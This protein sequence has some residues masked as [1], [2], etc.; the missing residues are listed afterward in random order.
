MQW[1]IGALVMFPEQNRCFAWL[2]AS[3]LLV[4]AGP[5]SQTTVRAQDWVDPR[6][7][8]GNEE[9]IS[10]SAYEPA[11]TQQNVWMV[12]EMPTPY[13][14]LYLNYKGTA[15]P[16]IIAAPSSLGATVARADDGRWTVNVNRRQDYEVPDQRAP[17]IQLSVEDASRPYIIPVQL[18]NVLDNAPVMT[19]ENYCEISELQRDFTSDCLYK[20][21]HAD[22]FEKGNIL[23]SSTNELSFEIEDAIANEHFEFWEVPE[24]KPEDPN[25]N[26][27]YN[28]RVKKQLDYAEKSL[29][30]FITTVYDLDRTHSFKMN[31]IV[32]VRNVDSRNPTFTRP[33]TTQRIME[34]EEF[35]TTVIAIDTDTELNNPICYRLQTLVLDYQKYF[36]I[37]ETSGEMIVQPIDRDTEK[38]ELYSFTITAYK[39]HN[40]SNRTSIDGAIILEDKNDCWPE[41]EVRPVELEFWENM[42]MELS[43]EQFIIDD[44]D[45]GENARYTVRLTETVGGQEQETDSFTIIPSSGY[46]RTAFT[47]NINNASKLDFEDPPRQSFQLHATAQEPSEPSHVRM[48]TIAIKLK[49]WNDEI[50]AFSEPEYEVSVR[51]TIEGNELLAEVTVTDRDIGDGIT[52]T[53]LGRIAESLDIV[54]LPI[55]VIDNVPSYSFQILTKVAN[56][57]DYDIAKEVIVQL[58]AQDKLQ[59]DRNEPLHR[60]FSQLSINVI[61][62]NN[63]P[64]QITLPRGTLH[65]V[66][67]SKPESPVIIGESEVGEI[68]GTDPDTEADLQFSIDWSSSY[69]TKS[70]VR[71]KED[72]YQGCFYIREER[73]NQQRTIGTLRVNPS[74]KLQVDYEMYDTLFLMIRLIDRNQTILPNSV[75][76]A[77]TVQIDDVNDNAPEFDNATLT[78]VRS[79]RER[80]DAGVTIGNII[81]YDIDGPGNN[82]ITFSMSPINPDHEGW[83]SID[84]N[85]IIRVE[86]NRT[87]DCDTP[88]IDVVLQSVTVSDW[89]FSTSHVFTI[90]LMDTNNKLPYHDPFPDEGRVFQFEKLQSKSVVAQVEGKDQDRDVAYHTV[91]YEINYRDFAQLQ[92]YF[93]VDRTGQVYVKENN[94]PLDR[95]G[96]LESITINVVMVDNAGGYDV[97]NRVST[98]IFLTLLDINDHYPELPELGEDS[99]QI[100]EDVKTGY[101]IKADLAALDRDDRLTP[102]AK[103]NYHIRQVSPAIGTSLFLLESVNE[104]NATLKAAR[105]F[106]GYY[107]NWTV[108]I[109]ACD[110]GSEYEPII[111]LPEPG[112]DN[113]RTRDYELV[114][115]P[116]NYQAPTIIYPVRNSQLRLKYESLYNGRP[117]NDTNGSVLP[118]FSAIDEDGGIYGDVTFTLQS[119]NE[120]DK[121]HEVFRIDKIDRKSGQLVLENALAVQPYPKNYSL[122]VIARDGGDKRTEVQINVV[123]IDMTG[124]PA[125]LE[126][127]FDTDFTE[128]EEGRDE[129]RQLPFAEDPKNAGLPPGAQTN[130]FYFIDRSYGNASHLFAL[131]PVTNV[132]RLAVLLDREEI[133]SHEIR[134]VATNNENGPPVPIVESSAALLVVRIK[135]NDVN[136]NPP[137]FQQRF[138]AAG[139]TTEDRVQKPLFR[140][141]ADDPDE[142][143]IIRY[144]IVAGSGETVG[145]NLPPSGSALPFRLD[146]NTGELTLQQKVLP[147]Q[148]GYYQFTIMAFDRDDTHNDTTTAKIYIVSESNR[149]TFVFLNSVE[150]IDQPDIRDFLAQQLSAAYDMECNID[151]IDQSI[152]TERQEQEIPSAGSSSETDVRTHFILN[153]QAVEASTIQQRSS[154]RT[155]VTELKTVL[156]TR[157]LSLQ[158]VPTPLEPLSEVNE[159]LQTVLIAVAG[160]LAVLCVI[161]FVAFFIKI[162]SLNRQLKALS[163]TDFGSISS[164]LN[165]KP[166]RTVP[167]TNIFSI[168]GSNPVLNDNEYGRHGGG[169][170]YYDDLSVQSDESDFTDM[171]KDMFATKRKE[172]LNPAF[173]EHIRQRSLNPMVNATVRSNDSGSTPVHQK[174]DETEDELSHRF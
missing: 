135:V 123:F 38:N 62:V 165:G 115:N 1:S 104:Y 173:M 131:D 83:M 37:G 75:E 101:T 93:E 42:V 74:F 63:K 81:A 134:V 55:V 8:S 128:N 6:F 16:N 22:G 24:G 29:F 132:L 136:D 89:L 61:D 53:A 145:E 30:N 154:N 26:I 60:I 73:I 166:T 99:S 109:E 34:K 124:E 79:V 153:N 114:I 58:Q 82:E 59:T 171:D 71:A 168:E 40:P 167:T 127:T 7:V 10:L 95:D 47:V 9:N 158:N 112:R 156:R 32:K 18:V 159:T 102:N 117:L 68:I 92:R 142:D 23:N 35:R 14:M 66:E 17:L 45:L 70:G 126:P 80:S 130:V 144:E 118:D 64:P 84:Q 25:H 11:F 20:V 160:A 139:I 152:A 121:D 146:G 90:V 129:R 94:E 76:V 77:I 85:G 162:R 87:I 5:A 43:F 31:T 161:L 105:D 164:E 36:S 97:Q 170:G 108:R 88:P 15:L 100:S 120:G 157:N 147:T 48:Q 169:G 96:G 155:F 51:E 150:E 110:R 12:E 113:C 50:P 106:K 27:L 119:T 137:V 133:P 148:K 141:F 2:L 143:E 13:V 56:I 65:I 116:F 41:F 33:F 52:I 107:G 72:T 86:G 98:N 28:L 4:L 149:V 140:V 57:F 174:V 46:Q 163:A 67:N 111:A 3:V 125:F 39:C 122:T 44:R 21:Y 54:A 69:G 19:A 91:S 49:N 103:I 172:S 151:D 138:Y 78:V